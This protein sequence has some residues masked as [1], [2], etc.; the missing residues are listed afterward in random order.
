MAWN[1]PHHVPRMCQASPNCLLQYSCNHQTLPVAWIP[2][3][4]PSPFQVMFK[5]CSAWNIGQQLL[6]F[7]FGLLIGW[8]MLKMI[9]QSETSPWKLAQ[10]LSCNN[11]LQLL[12]KFHFDWLNLVETLIKQYQTPCLE[13]GIPVLRPCRVTMSDSAARLMRSLRPGT[14]PGPCRVR[15]WITSYD[16]GMNGKSDIQVVYIYIHKMFLDYIFLS[17]IEYVI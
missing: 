10:C 5:P 15:T 2:I 13:G 12:V 11:V 16:G 14:A 4:L 9:K 6:L 1:S 3:I 7:S 17:N 8:K